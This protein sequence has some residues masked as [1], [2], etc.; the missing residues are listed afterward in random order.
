MINENPKKKVKI[1]YFVLGLIAVVIAVFDITVKSYY[2]TA[3]S[4]SLGI[5]FV[6]LGFKT[7]LESK[8][9]SKSVNVIH[10]ILLLIVIITSIAKLVYRLKIL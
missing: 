3:L 8:S 2:D 6:F 1:V 5:L 10:F 7:A 4:L 9:S